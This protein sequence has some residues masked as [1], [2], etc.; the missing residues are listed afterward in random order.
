MIVVLLIIRPKPKTVIFGFFAG[1]CVSN[2]G[3]MYQVSDKI[4]ARDTTSF[5]QTFNDLTKLKVKYQNVSEED[6]EGDYN[7]FKLDIPLFMLLDPRDRFGCP[8]CIDQVAYYLQ[9]TFF[10]ITRR[11]QIDP[12]HEPFY[13]RGLTRDIDEKIRQVASRL[14]Q[15]GG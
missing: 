5:W 13:F 6:D 7:E 12:G 4:I 11:F 1:E 8:G 15:Y 2:C 10:G 9:F 3:T 14:D